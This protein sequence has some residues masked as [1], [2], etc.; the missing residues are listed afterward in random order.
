MLVARG[1][2]RAAGEGA[3]G[4][5]PDPLVRSRRRVEEGLDRPLLS[6]RLEVRHDQ[7]ERFLERREEGLDLR[8]EDL[9]PESICEAEERHGTDLAGECDV[10]AGLGRLEPPG[11]QD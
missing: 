10:G 7:R 11:G 9:T 4:R 5:V 3:V 1:D 6:E 8:G 2:G